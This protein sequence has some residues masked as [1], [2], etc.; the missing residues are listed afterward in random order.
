MA[1]ATRSVFSTLGLLVIILYVFGIIFKQQSDGNQVLEKYFGTI[2][3]AMWN[4]LLSGTLLDNITIVLNDIAGE[5]WLL[6]ALFLL[7]VLISSFTV[8][9]MLIGVLCEV[10]SAVAQAEKEEM[11]VR[12]VKKQLLG[13]LMEIDEDN[14][15]MISQD[16]FKEF[17]NHDKAQLA[18][19]ALG[20]D[21]ENLLTLLDVIFAAEEELRMHSR[22]HHNDLVDEVKTSDET[23]DPNSRIPKNR[24]SFGTH[25]EIVQLSFGEIIEMILDLRSSKTAMVKDLVE[26]RKF[27]GKNQEHIL[28]GMGKLEMNNDSKF[29]ELSMEQRKLSARQDQFSIKQEEMGR[30]QDEILAV[31]KS[32]AHSIR[33]LEGQIDGSVVQPDSFHKATSRVDFS[34]SS[35]SLVR[36]SPPD[37]PP[38]CVMP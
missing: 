7:F 10:V 14:T 8:L 13:V 1:V 15:G 27:L 25:A 5:K 4:L 36:P 18:F 26:L 30:K 32:L 29:E 34:G 9:N 3:V 12:F 28:E 24:F 22:I 21:K 33:R 38:H 31:V 35:H 20:V 37:L 16:E 23:D 19:Q 11:V 6:S 17:V 2:S